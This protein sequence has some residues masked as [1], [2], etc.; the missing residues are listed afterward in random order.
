MFKL[1]IMARRKPGMSMDEFR[2]YYEKH[3]SVLVRKITPMM[4]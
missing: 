1:I 2:D 3:H 4:R